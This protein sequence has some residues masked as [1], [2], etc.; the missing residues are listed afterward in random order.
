L[1]KEALRSTREGFASRRR[2]LPASQAAI[3]LVLATSADLT[4]AALLALQP[5]IGL[6]L[7]LLLILI[8]TAYIVRLP[9]GQSCLCFGARFETH[10]LTTRVARNGGLLALLLLLIVAYGRDAQLQLPHMS[11]YVYAGSILIFLTGLDALI[12]VLTGPKPVQ[13]N[14]AA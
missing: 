7:A 10:S 2:S 1:P 5:R 8:Y 9:K 14:V 12:S 13:R 11:S 6:V 3:V 4:V